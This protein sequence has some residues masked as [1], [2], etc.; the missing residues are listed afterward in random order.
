MKEKV[1]WTTKAKE[2][3]VGEFE[4]RGLK[5]DGIAMFLFNEVIKARTEIKRLEKIIRTGR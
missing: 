5:G 4:K 1:N 2:E 3:L